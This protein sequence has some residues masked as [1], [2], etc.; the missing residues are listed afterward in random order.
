V[1]IDLPTIANIAFKFDGVYQHQNST[2]TNPMAG[3][4]GWNYYNRVGGRISALWKPIDGMK[5][6]L[7]YDQA[8]DENT[9]FYSQLVSYNPKNLPV[10]TYSGTTL[11]YNG[12]TCTNGKQCIAPLS[13]LVQVSGDKRQSAADVACRSS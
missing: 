12:A 8:K 5:V 7:S 10:G 13:P 2:V 3:Q 4:Y 11:M 9:P 6:E 1:H